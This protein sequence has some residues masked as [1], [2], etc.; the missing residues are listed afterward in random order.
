MTALDNL[1]KEMILDALK[2]ARGNITTAAGI[3]KTT[4]RK[5]GY[6]MKKY[7]IDYKT[8]RIGSGGI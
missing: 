4:V 8:Y 2:N 3:L 6:K 1:E 5:I 7:D